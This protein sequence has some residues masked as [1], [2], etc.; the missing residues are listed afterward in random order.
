MHWFDIR[1]AVR[2]ALPALVSAFAILQAAAAEFEVP[3]GQRQLFL[4]D[5]G[6]EE[7]TNLTRTLHAPE[8]R[9][10]VIRP[11]PP[12]EMAIQTRCAPAWNPER[13]VYQIWTLVSGMEYPTGGYAYFESKDGIHWTRPVL[14]QREVYGL[15]ENN[16]LADDAKILNAIYDADEPSPDRRY[17]GLVTGENRAPAVSPDGVHW[18]RLEVPPVPSW[19]ES[20]MSFDRAS[21]TYLLTVKQGG[22]YG[23]AVYLSTSQDFQNWTKPELA[24]CADEQDQ[25]LGKERI[26]RRFADPK[27][28]QPTFNI[29]EKYNVDVYNMGIF[30]YEGVYIGL[31]SMFHQTGK[32]DGTYK[33]FDDWDISPEM[34]AV[35]KRDG[36]WSGFHHIQMLCSRDLKTWTR[37][38]GRQ[39]FIDNSPAGEDVYDS[40]CII[41]PSAPVPH[42]DE[43]WF[44]YTGLK[45]YGGPSTA[46]NA[47]VNLAVLRRDGFFSLDAAD[48]EGTLLTKPFVL[49]GGELF[50]NVNAKKGRLRAELLDGNGRILARFSEIRGD[51]THK[52]L[53]WRG[54]DLAHWK[55]R[56][57]QLRLTLRNASLYS[58]WFEE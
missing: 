57:V 28:Q 55:G 12:H 5:H 21:H 4:D 16:Y 13:K 2:L 1:K 44:Y 53:K 29:P 47:A 19:D 32:V 23:R 51:R 31:P 48:D 14:N 52:K 8:K 50:V 34:R 35:Y 22:P 7:T 54:G 20:N 9:G 24:F 30:R 58:Y 11:Q 37:L 42:G 17:K 43:L 46:D 39:P 49:P 25:I 26:A 56:P 27:M 33:G 40:G 36:D 3:F 45:A 38:A 6:V 10:P 18:T 41:G 15:K